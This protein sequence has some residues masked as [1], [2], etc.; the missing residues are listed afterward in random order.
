MKDSDSKALLYKCIICSRIFKCFW[1]GIYSCLG[2]LRNPKDCPKSLP[3]TLKEVSSGLCPEHLH[4]I[5]AGRYSK[6]T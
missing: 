4:D 3:H 6:N 1:E 5:P 2:C